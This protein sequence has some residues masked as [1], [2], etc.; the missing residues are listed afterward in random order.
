MWLLSTKRAELHFFNGP[1]QVPGGYAVLSHVWD[2]NEQSFQELRALQERCQGHKN[3]RDLASEKVRQ[4]CWIAEIHGYKWIWN[5]TCCIDKT[6]SAELSE[7]INSMF[8]YY[9]LAKICYAYLRDVPA[10]PDPNQFQSDFCRSKWHTRGWTLQELLASKFVIFL[11]RYWQP[12][13]SKLELAHLLEIATGIPYSVLTLQRGL[14]D[15]SIAQRMSWMAKR[16]T[17]RA[18][19]AAYCLLGVFGIALPTLYGEGGNQAFQRLQEEIMRR[20]PDT[21]LFAWGSEWGNE[22]IYEVNLSHE[23]DTDDMYLFARSPNAFRDCDKEFTPLG[24]QTSPIAQVSLSSQSPGS[25]NPNEL[26]GNPTFSLTPHGLLSRIPGIEKG[27]LTIGVLGFSQSI[28]Q[29]ELGLLLTL[30]PRSTDLLR[31]LYDVG[32]A[33]SAYLD[34]HGLVRTKWVRLV[35]LG[36]V[37]E[38]SLTL[39]GERVSAQWKEIYLSHHPPPDMGSASL[40]QGP[41]VLLSYGYQ[42][43]FRFLEN[44]VE[45]FIR[46]TPNLR[47]DFV[48][49]PSE[50]PWDG[51]P[52]VMFVFTASSY[53]WTLTF[54]LRMGRC[55]H[56][57]VWVPAG[58]STTRGWHARWAR[59]DFCP[60]ASPNAPPYTPEFFAPPGS[61]GERSHDCGIDHVAGWGYPTK[62]F[63]YS[64]QQVTLHLERC[65]INPAG[66]YVVNIFATLQGMFHRPPKPQIPQVP[67]PGLG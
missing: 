59:V 16:S 64:G 38:E 58:S 46:T 15:V 63:V 11:T 34:E 42:A 40:Q 10:S 50:F 26:A 22:P 45:D 56:R 67:L 41:P 66:T 55:H 6:S 7:A 13:G 51:I 60:L 28:S 5:D 1:E 19:D 20:Y 23:H 61:E 48:R 37:S 25:R 57:R 43:P 24:S 8:R 65:P 18:E 39:F 32:M 2:Q 14:G 33:G 44:H 27:D 9:S 4:C 35:P 54:I 30:C 36:L 49:N 62:D 31:P 53:D 47:L 3:P 29:P 12:F 21:S 17:T 52:P